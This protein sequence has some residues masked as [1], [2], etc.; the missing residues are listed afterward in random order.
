MDTY[1]SRICLPAGALPSAPAHRQQDSSAEEQALLLGGLTCSA[2]PLHTE[3]Q[4]DGEQRPDLDFCSLS[5]APLAAAAAG[6]A[7]GRAASKVAVQAS[8]A[9]SSRSAATRSPVKR[10]AGAAVLV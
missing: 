5:I 8:H 1:S 4:E 7:S 10:Q 2:V 9:G 3:E 6:Q